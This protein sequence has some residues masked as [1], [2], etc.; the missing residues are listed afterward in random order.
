MRQ[1]TKTFRRH[2]LLLEKLISMKVR[3]RCIIG[4]TMI[5]ALLKELNW[6]FHDSLGIT[7]MHGYI[8]PINTSCIAKF[9]LASEFFIASFHMDK[10]ALIWFQDASEA[11]AFHSWEEFVQVVQIRFG[12]SPYDDP[13]EA[14]T[15]LK[16]VSI[17]TTYKTK[18]EVLSNRIRGIYEKNKLS[19]F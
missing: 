10:E 13:I 18:F 1:Q 17:V 6:S 8:G 15:H 11:G 3:V 19:F 4:R 12:S 2:M 5:E 14:L 7:H 9:L 16:H